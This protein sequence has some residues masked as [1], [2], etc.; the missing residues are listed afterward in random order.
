MKFQTIRDTS[1]S[2]VLLLKIISTVQRAQNTKMFILSSNAF[3]VGVLLMT[4]YFVRLTS[5]GPILV[6]IVSCI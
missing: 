5:K 1:E 4:F 2:E 6:T 3:F